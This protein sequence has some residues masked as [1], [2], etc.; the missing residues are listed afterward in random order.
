MSAGEAEAKRWAANGT[1]DR[2]GA[3]IRER[4]PV[5][6]KRTNGE[7]VTGYAIENGFAG[8]GLTVAWGA[9]GCRMA[10]RGRR[11]SFPARR[12]EQGR[13]HR[14]LPRVEPGHRWRTEPTMNIAVVILVAW[15]LCS[16]ACTYA[17]ER[18]GRP[19]GSR[20]RTR[21]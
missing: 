4:T 12:A 14:R 13:G 20:R 18:S 2:I 21:C 7:M 9:G 5:Q 6:I 1:F 19:R 16:Y 3:V 10:N 17:R 8:M 11:L 15:A